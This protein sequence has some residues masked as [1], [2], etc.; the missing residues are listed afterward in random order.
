[1]AEQNN[2]YSITGVLH[3]VEKQVIRGKKD[4]T[5]TFDKYLFTLEVTSSGERK[6]GNEVKY[7]TDTQFPQFE[8]FN[9]RGINPDDFTIGDLLEIRFFLEGKKFTR[10][11]GDRAG[12][13]GIM[14]KNVITFIRF[15]D[16]NAGHSNHKGKVNVNSM[17][18]PEELKKIQE[19]FVPPSDDNNPDFTD[20]P[21]I[22]SALIGIGSLMIF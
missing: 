21:F 7:A 1:M 15:A 17:T 13:E 19:T 3:D 18:N 9:L 14:N 22:I 4:V 2:S 20:L 11:T 6:R 12:Q 10:K 5:Q 16:L 8:A